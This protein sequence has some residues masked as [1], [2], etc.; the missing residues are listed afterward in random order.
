M[1]YILSNVVTAAQ[2]RLTSRHIARVFGMPL[3][4]VIDATQFPDCGIA[5]DLKLAP[6]GERTAA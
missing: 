5:A 4:S 6:H 2:G 3:G 1:T